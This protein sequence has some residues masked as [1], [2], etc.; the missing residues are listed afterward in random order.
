ME[1]KIDV[2]DESEKI[3][4]ALAMVGLHFELETSWLIY[5]TIIS[6]QEKGGN[7]SVSDAVDIAYYSKKTFQKI[8]LDKEDEYRC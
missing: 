8:N 3:R 6:Y 2:L 1:K 4:T 5:K 7:F